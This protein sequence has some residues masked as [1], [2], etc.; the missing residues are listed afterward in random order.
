MW[1]SLAC[2]EF[3]LN[4]NFG[5]AQHPGW[6]KIS[7]LASKLHSPSFAEAWGSLWKS[8]III[9]NKENVCFHV[10]VKNQFWIDCGKMADVGQMSLDIKWKLFFHGAFVLLLAILSPTAWLLM[11]QVHTLG[12]ESVCFAQCWN[13]R[14]STLELR[15]QAQAAHTDTPAAQKASTAPKLDKKWS[16]TPN[17]GVSAPDTFPVTQYPFWDI[18]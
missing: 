13:H 4:T 3:L 12:L 9:E 1:Y 6:H 2:M 17:F 15:T 16:A 11:S 7:A 8:S 14:N 10:L 5:A 18:L